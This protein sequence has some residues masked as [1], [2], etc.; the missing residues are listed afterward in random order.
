LRTGLGKDTVSIN[1]RVGNLADYIS[2]GETNNKTVLGRLVFV[3]GL[4]A[5]TFT[6]TV[7]GTS[8]TTTTELNL[9]AAEVGLALLYLC[10]SL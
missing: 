4:A 8:L 6:L 5:Q 3:L 1:E 2:V 7:I 10:E 9:V